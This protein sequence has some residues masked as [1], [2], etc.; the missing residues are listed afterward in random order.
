M[1]RDLVQFPFGA[2]DGL[3]WLEAPDQL[4]IVLVLI[5]RGESHGKEQICR[6]EEI[7]LRRQNPNDGVAPFIER[8]CLPDDLRVLSK[9]VLPEAMADQYDMLVTR[10]KL[11]GGERAPRLW[12]DAEQGQQLTGNPLPSQ[13]LE[14]CAASK[15]EFAR[16][17]SG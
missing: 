9:A 13:V 15:R 3:P 1:A 4:E 17:E 7:E 2:L 5:F 8:H 11:F 14:R 12:C 10:L 16:L 6:R